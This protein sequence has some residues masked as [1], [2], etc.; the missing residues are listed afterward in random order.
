MS[1]A[2]LRPLTGR[3]RPHILCS[4]RSGRPHFRLE[5][6]ASPATPA[7]PAPVKVRVFLS[8]CASLPADPDGV[9]GSPVRRLS[10]VPSRLRKGPG[11]R[12]PGWHQGLTISG[13]ALKSSRRPRRDPG[14]VSPSCRGAAG[15]VP[16]RPLPSLPGPR[17]RTVASPAEASVLCGRGVQRAF[18]AR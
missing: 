17:P 11:R 12:L 8:R 3:F 10:T 14:P 13:A 1:P 15:C 5:D 7:M 18:P 4:C 16:P 6:G 2:E 9:D